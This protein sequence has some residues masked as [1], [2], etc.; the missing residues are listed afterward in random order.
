MVK[1]LRSDRGSI[2][3]VDYNVLTVE[4]ALKIKIL[5]NNRTV[6]V[7]SFKKKGGTMTH[8]DKSFHLY[9][10]PGISV[11]SALEAICNVQ[12]IVLS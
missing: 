2:L 3:E 6:G 5:L 11:C 10:P 12:R 9:Y 7:T 8:E 1:S 4:R